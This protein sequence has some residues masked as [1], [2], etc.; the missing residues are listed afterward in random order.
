ML[1]LLIEEI[2]SAIQDQEFPLV[3]SAACIAV[4]FFQVMHCG[5]TQSFLHEFRALQCAIVA[6][7][8]LVCSSINNS[9]P[10]GKS[11]RN[12]IGFGSIWAG[13]ILGISIEL[14]LK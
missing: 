13:L 3:A 6:I 7:G 9:T 11:Y 2:S 8:F 14:L 10:E 5:T 1:S 12:F 4:A